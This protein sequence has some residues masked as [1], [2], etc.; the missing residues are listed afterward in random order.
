MQY[1]CAKFESVM[2]RNKIAGK[3]E[4]LY[5]QLV[6]VLKKSDVYT[7]Q[8]ASV[9]ALLYHKM[10]YFF[11]CGFYMVSEESLVVGPYQGPIACM[12]LPKNS[13]VCWSAV[14]KKSSVVIEDVE[15]FPG[16]IACDGRSKSEVVIPLLNSAGEVFAVLDVDSRE[17]GD[18]DAIDV[19]W[20]TK[21][22]EL[23][24]KPE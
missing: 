8:M 17:V 5:K 9:A 21:I 18:F 4:R 7:A 23:I 10:D 3:Y 14:N 6:P 15:A 2:K 1:L 12:H 16:H 19:E 20:L 11:W 13:G 24:T 22:G